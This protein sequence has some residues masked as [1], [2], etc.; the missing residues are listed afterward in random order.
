[1]NKMNRI[2]SRSFVMRL[3]VCEVDFFIDN[4]LLGQN[5]ND[6][7]INIQHDQDNKQNREKNDE[8]QIAY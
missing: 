6:A 1:M 4:D 3:M 5:V 8:H 7:L 2:R